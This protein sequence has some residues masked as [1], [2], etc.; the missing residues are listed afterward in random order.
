MYINLY[1]D[2]RRA[3]FTG[4]V[5]STLKIV[6]SNCSVNRPSDYSLFG[7]S[8]KTQLFK[9]NESDDSNTKLI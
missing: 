1:L 2:L 3:L 4:S 9:S 5:K 7:P 6:P 8:W